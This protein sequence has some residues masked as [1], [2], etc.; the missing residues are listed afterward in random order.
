AGGII[1]FGSAGN[2]AYV[3]LIVVDDGGNLTETT[4]GDFSL[5]DI[6]QPVLG[7]LTLNNTAPIEFNIDASASFF[8]DMTVN[9]SGD[10][11]FNGAA[12]ST[13]WL[14]DTAGHGGTIRF[15]GAGD[16]VKI[17][18]AN[19]GVGALE[20]N[21][22]GANTLF[23]DPEVQSDNGTVIFN[24]PGTIDHAS[25]QTA[26]TRRR[27][28]GMTNLVANAP[29]T[30]DLSKGF[31]NDS[32]LID[33]RRFL[34][35]TSL[36]GSGDITVNGM[37]FDPT[38]PGS[39]FW[40]TL[41]E[42][43]LGS[44][45]DVVPPTSEYS[46]VVTANNYVNVEI[47]HNLPNARIVINSNA[48]MDAGVQTVPGVEG[49]SAVLRD[50]QVG[51]IV[52]NNGGILEVGFEQDE[53]GSAFFQQTG[54]HVG[55][56]VLVNNDARDGDLTLSGGATLRMQINGTANELFDRITVQGDVALDGTLDVLISPP[57]SSGTANANYVPTIGDVFNIITLVSGPAGAADFDDSGAIDGADLDVWKGAFGVANAAG[58][59][60]GDADTDGADLL[61]W[62]RS[63]GAGGT[64]GAIT[65][66]FDAINVI[67]PAGLM[68]GKAIQLVKTASA[69]QLHVVAA[70]AAI[71]EPAA[72]SLA[73]LAACGVAV[74]A[75]RRR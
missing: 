75:R 30:V 1:N 48:R 60:D 4:T 33:E 61:A 34:I 74:A 28:H 18:E 71:P 52:V 55:H 8:L 6:S 56:L 42:F 54:H 59:A 50:I 31:P 2:A 3:P 16:Q 38:N 9:G 14:S 43:E 53:T 39:E 47:R 32:G 7:T 12:G 57:S 29:I 72:L 49:S 65:G 11:N 37:S 15:N 35:G 23:F 63:L 66:D 5:G 10:L 36:A 62:Q 24:Q 73:V 64:V 51:E 19:G 40:T 27:L 46:G 26:P 45:G 21:S 25:T 68:A 44:S 58:D 70:V 67:D 69:V 41:N 22:T 17:T 13:L 20:M